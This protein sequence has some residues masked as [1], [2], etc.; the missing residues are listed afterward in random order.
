MC[1]PLSVSPTDPPD[2]LSGV[3]APSPTS[4]TRTDSG[5]AW[6]CPPESESQGPAWTRQAAWA[7]VAHSP[8]LEWGGQYGGLPGG[9]SPRPL[10]PGS[11]AGPCLASH[12]RPSVDQ[13]SQ[14]LAPSCGWSTSQLF[15]SPLPPGKEG[16]RGSVHP[17]TGVQ[18]GK[19]VCPPDGR[20]APAPYR[21]PARS[22]ALRPDL[23]A[24]GG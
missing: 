1:L 20:Y 23:P 2:P 15:V 3:P 21:S 19:T 22:S 10:S 5:W 24:R 17:P 16:V 9:P 18:D 4:H 14:V 12:S 7:T 6:L 8:A 11:H 13:T